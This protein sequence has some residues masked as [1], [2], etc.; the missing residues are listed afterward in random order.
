MA[1]GAVALGVSLVWF[2]GY[3]KSAKVPLA[4]LCSLAGGI[5]AGVA[6]L[7]AGN[8]RCPKC[9]GNFFFRKGEYPRFVLFR[10]YVGSHCATCGKRLDEAVAPDDPTPNAPG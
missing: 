6:H 2:G 1:R 9:G 4:M 5:L 10:V 3:L 8:F 7:I